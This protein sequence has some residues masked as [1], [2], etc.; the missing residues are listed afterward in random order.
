MGLRNAEFPD[1]QHKLYSSE[2]LGEEIEKNKEQIVQQ[3]IR[4]ISG[5]A[6]I[7]TVSYHG[8]LKTYTYQ[9]FR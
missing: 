9:C 5:R 1:E 7:R 6:M 4:E 8:R 3:K 2:S